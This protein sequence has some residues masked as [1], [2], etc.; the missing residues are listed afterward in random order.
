MKL[1][2]K[3]VSVF[4]V[5]ASLTQAQLADAVG[6]QME[7]VAS[8]EQGRRAFLPDL[9]RRMDELLDTKG[10]LSTAV[11]N[12]PEV[13]LVPAWAEQYVTPPRPE[14]RGFSLCR[15]GVATDQPGP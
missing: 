14:G 12:M 1:V 9:A 7:T 3:L 11:E 6:I 10:A 13:D 2:G 5:A 15:V 8:I 4:R